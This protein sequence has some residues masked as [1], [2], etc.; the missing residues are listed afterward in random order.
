MASSGWLWVAA[1][2]FGWLRKITSGWRMFQVVS[3]G[4]WRFTV[5]VAMKEL[6]R[7]NKKHFLSF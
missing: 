6:F 7:W 1:D 4:F 5:L 3:G 2:G